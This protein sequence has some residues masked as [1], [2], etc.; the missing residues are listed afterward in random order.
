M[1]RAWRTEC[2]DCGW[3]TRAADE[4]YV[5]GAARTHE[6]LKPG[7]HASD[8]RPDGDWVR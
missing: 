3:S 1:M 4:P 7:H 8:P 5:A 6:I 2:V